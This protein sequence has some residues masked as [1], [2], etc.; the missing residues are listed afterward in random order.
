MG[1][2]YDRSVAGKMLR[3]GCHPRIPHALH[4]GD[5]KLAYGVRARVESPIS[6]HIIDA[7]VQIHTGRERG[8]EPVRP[9]FGCHKPAHASRELHAYADIQVE[10]FT[11]PPC[12]WQAREAG[13]EALY[14]PTLL[15]HGD[16]QWRTTLGMNRSHQG[17]ELLR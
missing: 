15:I 14:T 6:N 9:Q 7:V 5:R 12:G 16:D 4:I 3:G 17:R 11:D 8:V 2:G 1:I 13:T 10:F